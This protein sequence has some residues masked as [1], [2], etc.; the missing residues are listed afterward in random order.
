MSMPVWTTPVFWAAAGAVPLTMYLREVMRLRRLWR[1][2]K[3][4][5]GVV[6]DNT[7]HGRES[8]S[9]QWQPLIAFYDQ[10]GHRVTAEPTAATYEKMRV[11]RE[12]PVVYW[13]HN[14]EGM[15]IATRWHLMKPLL[16]HSPLLI[17][18]LVALAGALV[19]AIHLPG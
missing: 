4:T 12:V 16:Y 5:S 10:H 11:G 9:D 7:N 15:H 3:S 13:P 19:G 6:V 2:G 8:N 18:G 17:I 14:P 1:D